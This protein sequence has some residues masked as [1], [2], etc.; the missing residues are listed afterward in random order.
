M[1][2]KWGGNYYG[3]KFP[4]LNVALETI[5]RDKNF[6]EIS[7]EELPPVKV[8]NVARLRL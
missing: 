8:P 3:K 2:G 5:K 7:K 1:H 4:S 6:E